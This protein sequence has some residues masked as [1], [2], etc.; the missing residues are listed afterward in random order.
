MDFRADPKA[1]LVCDEF[2]YGPAFLVAPVTKPKATSRDVYLPTGAQ[3]I[4]FWTGKK[5]TGGQAVSTAAP[6]DQIPLYVRAGSIIPFGPDVQYADEKPADPIELRI[7]PG[8]DGVFTLYE[9]QGDN[10]NYEKGVYATTPFAWS[11]RNGTL[12]LGARSGRFP[13]MLDTRMFRIVQVSTNHGSGMNP[14]DCA[15]Q[16]KPYGGVAATLRFGNQ[17][18]E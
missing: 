1:Q 3:W 15:D 10:Y 11:D 9:D 8:A 4:D 2:M 12:T 16:E 5:Y 6:L 13:G 7:Y 18:A 17:S 14:T